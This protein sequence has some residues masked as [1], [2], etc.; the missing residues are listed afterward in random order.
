M[1]LEIYQHGA[2]LY[3]GGYGRG[4]AVDCSRFAALA[5]GTRFAF[6]PEQVRILESYLLDGEQWMIR[7]HRFDYSACGRE[8]VR[9]GAGSATS[10]PGAARALASVSSLVR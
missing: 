4:F 3:S 10:F 6:A 2:Q 7:N 5:A 1:F 9:K 8:I